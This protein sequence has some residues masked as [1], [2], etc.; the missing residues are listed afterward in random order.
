[1]NAQVSEEFQTKILDKIPKCSEFRLSRDTLLSLLE[2]AYCVG[3]ADGGIE[4]AQTTLTS[5]FGLMERRASD[6]WQESSHD[7]D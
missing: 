7:M 2:G 3:L 5:I 4:G 6:A 1:M